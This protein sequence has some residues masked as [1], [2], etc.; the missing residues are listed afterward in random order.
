MQNITGKHAIS[1][2]LRKFFVVCSGRNIMVTVFWDTEAIVLIDY[3]GNMVA[4]SQELTTL[5]W[6]EKST[7]V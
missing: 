1:P 7:L 5:N 3:T 6:P 4:L 2:P